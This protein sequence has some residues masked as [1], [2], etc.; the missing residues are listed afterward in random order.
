MKGYPTIKYW[1]YGDKKSDSSAKD[2]QGGREAAQIIDFASK[3]ANSADIDPTIH[4]LVKQDIY[5][6]E[7]EGASGQKIC[8]VFFVP[9]IYDSSSKERNSY[10][11]VYKAIAK[12]HRSSPYVFFWLQAG[13]Q[14]DLERQLNLGFG[15]PAIV[16][17]S[18]NKK[19]FATMKASFKKENVSDFLTG[20]LTGKESLEDIRQ[21]IALKKRQIWDGKDAAPPEVRLITLTIIRTHHR[22]CELVHLLRILHL[23]NGFHKQSFLA[24]SRSCYGRTKSV[25]STLF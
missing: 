10:L 14:L 16:A 4:E 18:P 3:L 17:I 5:K 12:K 8:V 6:D 2:Y 11:E 13:D 15:F 21:D 19:V 25:L 22:T 24:L 23:L 9:N 20:L 7:C 1:D